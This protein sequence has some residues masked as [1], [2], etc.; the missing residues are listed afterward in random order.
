MSV[1]SHSISTISER[2]ERLS[3]SEPMTGCRL[4]LGATSGSNGK[5][6]HL[7]IAGRYVKAHR[8][9]YEAHVGPIPEGMEIDHRCNQTLCIEPAH[10]RPMTGYENTLRSGGIVA[11]RMRA[12]A[13]AMWH[14]TTENGSIYEVDAVNKRFRRLSGDAE[15]TARTEGGR[16]YD[17]LTMLPNRQLLVLW[18]AD[19]PPLQQYP[20]GVKAI[21]GTLTSRIV[22]IQP[23]Y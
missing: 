19:T 9:S 17:S 2:L 21:P 5:Y 1:P 16:T 11:Q 18:S 6:G 13:K 7:K 12:K 23:A 22:S 10:L 4:W 15:P 14:L 20:E 3:Q 8:A